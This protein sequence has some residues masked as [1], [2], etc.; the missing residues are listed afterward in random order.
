LGNHYER[1]FDESLSTYL[2]EL[3]KK[4]LMQLLLLMKTWEISGAPSFM[5]DDMFTPLLEKIAAVQSE[6]DAKRITDEI[7]TIKKDMGVQ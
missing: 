7:E 3:R 2:L 4:T 1:I 5:M 6:D